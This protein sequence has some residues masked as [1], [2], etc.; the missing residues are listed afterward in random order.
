MKC[1]THISPSHTLYITFQILFVY[2]EQFILEQYVWASNK[3]N[4]ELYFASSAYKNNTVYEQVYDG[5]TPR[6]LMG[7]IV[8]GE[9]ELAEANSSP[10]C[11]I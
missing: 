11:V 4:Q 5:M 7:Q 3:L 1:F 8:L 10:F 2:L 9:S 6:T